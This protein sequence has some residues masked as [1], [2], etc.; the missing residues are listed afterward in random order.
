MQ[1][2]SLPGYALS[3]VGLAGIALLPLRTWQVYGHLATRLPWRSSIPI[4]LLWL[5]IGTG[6]G[7][8]LAFDVHVVVRVLRSLT[9][10]GNSGGWLPLAMLGMVYLAFE[11][12][13]AVALATYRSLA[14]KPAA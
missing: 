7:L 14:A 6:A 3:I 13:V 2:P 9:G 4:K 5:L 8:A 12:L 10:P 11:V 1:D